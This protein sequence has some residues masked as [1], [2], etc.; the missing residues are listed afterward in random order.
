MI[1]LNILK[2]I[3]IVLVVLLCILLVLILLVLFYPVKYRI[4]GTEVYDKEN[5]SDIHIRLSW[6]FHLIGVNMDIDPE[7]TAG[8]RILFVKKNLMKDSDTSNDR[9][10]NNGDGGSCDSDSCNSDS[11]EAENIKNI[12]ETDIKNTDNIAV[13]EEKI[14]ANATKA[15]KSV[16]EDEYTNATNAYSNNKG[17]EKIKR[18]TGKIKKILKDDSCKAALNKI[19]TELIKLLK[20]IMPYKLYLKAEFSAGSP[21]KTGMVLGILAMFPIGYRNKWKIRPDFEREEIYIDSEFDIK[22][23]IFL[24]KILVIAIRVLVDKNCRKLYNEIRK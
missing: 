20:A 16:S 14:D 10:D 19:K 7:L 11:I 8:L 9:S 1:F 2:I 23:H 22:G 21:D 13:A 6:I 15:E 3:G 17:K 24:Y 5:K 4:L 12:S 18:L